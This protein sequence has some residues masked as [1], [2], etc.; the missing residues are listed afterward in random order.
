M[1]RTEREFP[2]LFADI[3][4]D[5]RTGAVMAGGLSGTGGAK[6]GAA[7]KQKLRIMR[8]ESAEARNK[9]NQ[10]LILLL[11]N[12]NDQTDLVLEA[13]KTGNLPCLSESCGFIGL[14]PHKKERNVLRPW[15]R[16]GC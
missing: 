11:E 12:Y 14:F 16:G 3:H 5:T 2:F 10:D 7:V 13:L 6:T 8:E 4:Y 15:E 9:S 1:S